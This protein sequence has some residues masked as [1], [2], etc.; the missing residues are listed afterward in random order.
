MTALKH[1]LSGVAGIVLAAGLFAA[2]ASAQTRV[3]MSNDNNALGVKGKTFELLKSELEKRLGDKVKVELHHSGSLFDQGTQVQGLQL[4]SAHI[5]APGMGQYAPHAP[6]VN[7]LGLPFLFSSAE[8]VQ[9]AVNDPEIRDVIFSELEAK[10]IVPIAIWING[11]RDFSYKRE[12][13]VLLPADMQGLKIRVQST[14]VDLKTMSLLGA[15]TV[16][17]AWTEVPT[18]LQ[19]GV[20]DAV[21]PVPNALIG[22]SL[23]EIISQ[24]SRVNWQYNFYIVGANKQWWEGMPADVKAAF[25]EA[26]DVATKW[27]W[28]NTERENEEAYDKVRA[29]GKPVHDITPEQRA[30]WVEAVKPIWDEFGAPL[31]GEKIMERLVTIEKKHAK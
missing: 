23:H 7:T 5:I 25:I 21:E 9:E 14:P 27:N 17:M 3:I 30:Q 8:A 13:P 4:G 18:A 31:V 26:M 15:N 12:K 11:P 2:D 24:V 20:I 22:A 16:G 1:I 28:E 29:L 6:K 10:N 19:Q